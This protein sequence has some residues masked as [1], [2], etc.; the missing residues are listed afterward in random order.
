MVLFWS[1]ILTVDLWKLQKITHLRSWPQFLPSVFNA[2]SILPFSAED[3]S[4]SF[5]H[6]KGMPRRKR[7][8]G[9]SRHFFFFYSI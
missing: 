4:F 7:D 3:A 6:Q 5:Q 9:P 1:K 2:T 8:M